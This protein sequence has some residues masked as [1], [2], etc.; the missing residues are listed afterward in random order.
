MKKYTADFETTTDPE[1]C[2]VWAYAICSV[3]KPED[4]RWGNNLDNFFLEVEKNP[5][6]YYFHNLKFDGSFILEWLFSHNF[7]W[8][9]EKKDQPSYTF[10]TLITDMGLFYA[11]EVKFKKSK[12]K[13][14]DSL[15]IL[16][17]SV[18]QIAKDFD[19]P[20]SK[21]E[22]DYK[23]KRPVGWQLTNQEIA[24][25]RNDVEIMAR[26]M[27]IM[28][29]HNLTKMTIGSCALSDYRS[30]M[31]KQV[32]D[33]IFPQL[34]L[35]VDKDI[36]E[37]YRGGWTYL[38]PIYKG[39]DVG[40]GLVL[41]RNSMYPSVMCQ[42]AL[43]Y[44]LPEFFDGQYKF[45]KHCPLFIQSFSCIF[46]LKPGKLPTI[47]I[48]NSLS[49]L[50][51]EWLESSNGEIV[52]LNLCKPDYELFFENYIVRH[53]TFH[54][55]WKF[56]AMT[57]MFD[58]YIRSWT[59]SK[60]KS[61][62][63]G[64]KA[65]Y[66]IS[67]LMLNSLYGKLGSNPISGQKMPVFDGEMVHLVN[68]EPEEK[69]PLYI[70]MASFITSYARTTMIRTSQY[71]RDYSQKK[72]GYDAFIY[73]D[74]DSCHCVLKPEDLEEISKF[75]KIDPYELGAWDM[76]AVFTR[77]KYLRQKCYIEEIDGKITAHI[78]GLPSKL[79]QYITFENFHEGFSTSELDPKIR[80]ENPKLRYKHVPGGVI[81]EEVDFTIK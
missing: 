39:K 13:F 4:F 60:V 20:I 41:D 24:Y 40:E 3:D 31:S 23:Q 81:L 42:E 59:D 25:I 36:R 50:L 75:I 37:S 68:Q 2:R 71:I 44:G 79:A 19:L 35:E 55:G 32:F 66:L 1:D 78:A 74:T 15:K 47:Q 65:L 16:N 56:Q 49:F 46:E 48:K 27:K 53:L 21:L 28:E 34:P 17:F 29:E 6:I 43:P 52:T 7:D 54:G 70:P 30:R 76:E 62:Q 64:N 72:Y 80:E 69:D 8:V 63:E 58:D 51:N 73:S 22:I 26:A 5:G 61:K 38:N 57:G 10:T 45:D 9:K 14:Y 67:K 77:G 33:T 11:I 12:V 18:S